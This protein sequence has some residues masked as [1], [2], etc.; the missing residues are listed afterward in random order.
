MDGSAAAP[1]APTSTGTPGPASAPSPAPTGAPT[2]TGNP[3][4]AAPKPADAGASGLTAK[5]Q[6]LLH[7]HKLEDGTELDV[8]ISGYEHTFKIDG[9]EQKLPLREALRLSQME[10][11]STKRFEEVKQERAKLEAERADLIRRAKALNDPQVILRHLIENHREAADKLIEEH[12]AERIKRERMTPEAR[13]RLE[14]A[15]QLERQ[16]RQREQQLAERE[17]RI[18]EQES[19]IQTERRE[20]F[21]AQTRKEWP[22]AFKLMGIPE[23]EKATALAYSATKRRVEFAV[24]NK[25]EVD[26]PLFQKQAVEDVRKLYEESGR[27]AAKRTTEAVQAQPGRTPPAEQPDPIAAK[28]KSGKT[29]RLD[30]F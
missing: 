22:E 18:Q 2:G 19:K 3:A 17:R 28:I 14:Q 16:A 24:Q 5:E 26:I 12:L 13:Q 7:K 1:V 11:T 15:E 4:V 29:L 6:R 23:G 25:L 10:R 21:W 9:R 20:R 8:D 27:Y 30:D